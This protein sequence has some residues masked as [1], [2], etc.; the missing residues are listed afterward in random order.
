MFRTLIAAIIALSFPATASA[1]DAEGHQIIASIAASHLNR[2][3][4][5]ELRRLAAELPHSGLPYNAITIACWMDDIRTDKAAPDYGLFKT[6]HYIDI[7]IDPRDPIP[8]FEP[9][10]DNEQHG[11]AVQALKRAVVVLKGGTDPYIKDKATACAIVMHLVGDIHQPLHC[12][13]KFFMS[14]DKL[15][16]DRGGNDELVVNAPVSPPGALPFN[17]H[18]FWDQAYKATFNDSTGTLNFDSH[19]GSFRHDAAAPPGSL[20][21]DF[22]AWAREGN[23]LAR[24]DVYRDLTEAGDRKHCRLSSAYVERARPI[25]QTRMLLAGWRLATLLNEILGAP[26]PN[27]PPP[28]YP[29]GPPSQPPF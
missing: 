7:S 25:A 27:P 17:L 18:F 22:D 3:A 20:E 13:S 2:D 19:N 4:A 21:P 11:D 23:T 28:S 1:W 9:G 24:D 6:W 12:A 8:S 16:N 5:A 29:A 10:N 26:Q 15:L 14:H